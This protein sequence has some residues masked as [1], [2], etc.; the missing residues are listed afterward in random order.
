MKKV[1]S[2]NLG[3]VRSQARAETRG[4][5]FAYQVLRGSK[6]RRDPVTNNTGRMR[7]TP[8]CPVC[9][10]VKV[11]RTKWAQL[12][13]CVHCWNDAGAPSVAESN[14]IADAASAAYL[15]SS[16]EEDSPW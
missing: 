1:R 4:L 6:E 3:Q 11:L 14:L 2:K 7:A 8:V 5:D 15:E 10:D 13:L 12:P 9:R 16:Q